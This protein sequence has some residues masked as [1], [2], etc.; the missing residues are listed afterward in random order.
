MDILIHYYQAQISLYE[1]YGTSDWLDAIN[2]E[3]NQEILGYLSITVPRLDD[4][5]KTITVKDSMI[6][7]ITGVLQE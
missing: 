4:P 6:Y 5:T 2:N 3:T 1:D 7:Q